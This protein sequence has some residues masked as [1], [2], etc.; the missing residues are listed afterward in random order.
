MTTKADEVGSPL[1]SL[2]DEMYEEM[3]AEE[4][5]SEKQKALK[6]RMR[7]LK[8]RLVQGGKS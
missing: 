3:L 5:K 4:C 7:K 6:R 8:L 1:Q 2:F